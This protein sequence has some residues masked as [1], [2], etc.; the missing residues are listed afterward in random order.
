[1]ARLGFKVKRVYGVEVSHE[2][3]NIP[4]YQQRCL[5]HHGVT[6][7]S[8]NYAMAFE[9]TSLRFIRA[10]IQHLRGQHPLP[11]ACVTHWYQFD[12]GFP[13]WVIVNILVRLRDNA[14][15]LS[16]FACYKSV[17]QMHRLIEESVGEQKGDLQLGEGRGSVTSEKAVSARTF[18]DLLCLH[19]DVLV[20]MEGARTCTAKRCYMYGI[21][22][23]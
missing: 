14:V 16:H 6:E 22:E 20:S 1:M 4:R 17:A 10:D 23:A 2:R 7:A 11:W 18:V 3:H 21:R 13:P 15:K 5:M 9:G 12:I 19:R 8:T